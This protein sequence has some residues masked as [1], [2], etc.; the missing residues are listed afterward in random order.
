MKVD[1]GIWNWLTQAVI[2]LVVVAILVFIFMTY[3]PLIQQNERMRRNLE[4]LR[5]EFEKQAAI[6]K[7][8]GEEIQA[9]RHDPQ[10]VARL[11]R[12]KLGY[13]K[14]GEDVIRFEAASTNGGR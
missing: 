1:F 2:A 6:S 8:L 13:A 11:A 12:E 5:T 14:P 4:E 10:T 9:L 7:Q 3:L